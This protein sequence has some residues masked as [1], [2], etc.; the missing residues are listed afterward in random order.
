MITLSIDHHGRDDSLSLLNIGQLD[1]FPSS[2]SQTAKSVCECKTKTQSFKTEENDVTFL[3]I[4]TVNYIIT[5]Q[6]YIKNQAITYAKTT[7][8]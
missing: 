4:S 7:L 2:S 6:Q 1:S 8:F 5:S 3:V